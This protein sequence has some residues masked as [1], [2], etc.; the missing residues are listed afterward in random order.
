MQI[1]ALSCMFTSTTKQHMK[2][3]FIS[4]FSSC[5]R[6]HWCGCAGPTAL[7]YWWYLLVGLL[8]RLWNKMKGRDKKGVKRKKGFFYS[9]GRQF[10]FFPWIL[11]TYLCGLQRG[12]HYYNFIAFAMVHLYL[13]GSYGSPTWSDCCLVRWLGECERRAVGSPPQM[14]LGIIIEH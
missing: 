9:N 3:L 4:I 6:K 1:S 5:N 2:F 10:I 12:T 11:L 8:G 7:L 14:T 13:H